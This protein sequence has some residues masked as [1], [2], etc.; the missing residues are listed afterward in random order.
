[1]GGYW[2]SYEEATASYDTTM[3]NLWDAMGKL[4]EAMRREAMGGYGK[5]CDGWLWEA[6]M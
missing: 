5:L 4:W 3:G 6:I 1:M 2:G